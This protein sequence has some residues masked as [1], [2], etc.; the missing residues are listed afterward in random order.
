MGTVEV[1]WAAVFE[2]R[3]AGGRAKINL[4]GCLSSLRN[5]PANRV[6]KPRNA[7]TTASP[8]ERAPVEKFIC[9]LEEWEGRRR[10]YERYVVHEAQRKKGIGERGKSGKTGC[11]GSQVKPW[12][13][14]R[15]VLQ[16]SRGG[17]L[18]LGY[19]TTRT[20]GGRREGRAKASARGTIGRRKE[21]RRVGGQPG[22]DTPAKP[23][24]RATPRTGQKTAKIRP[25]V[26]V[27]GGEREGRDGGADMP[28]L[29]NLSG[30]VM[31]RSGRILSLGCLLLRR[32]ERKITDAVIAP[33]RDWLS[34]KPTKGKASDSHCGSQGIP[35]W[36][37]SDF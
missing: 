15:L 23:A 31:D 6:E 36:F 1:G 8:G 32:K 16:D 5:Y 11:R 24:D 34:Q 9:C 3:K 30:G 21:K 33:I 28:A 25:T 22:Q 18:R 20:R 27:E 12:A 17:A 13:V 35:G 14:K 7:R 2:G 19:V 26:R 29:G 4:A 37:L 10:H